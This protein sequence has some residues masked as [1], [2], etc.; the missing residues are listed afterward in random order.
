MLFK[1][2]QLKWSRNWAIT[3]KNYCG[4]FRSKKFLLTMGEGRKKKRKKGRKKPGG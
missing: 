2:R 3:V 1:L 4:K